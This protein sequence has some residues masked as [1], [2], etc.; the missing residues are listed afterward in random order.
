MN[1][2]N[3]PTHMGRI[4]TR[5]TACVEDA[6]D[7]TVVRLVDPGQAPTREELARQPSQNAHAHPFRLDND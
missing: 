2:Y 7:L 5:W 6:D 1:G 3:V 4:R